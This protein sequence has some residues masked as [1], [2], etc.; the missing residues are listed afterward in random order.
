M[1]K[2]EWN[3]VRDMRFFLSLIFFCLLMLSS[4]SHS[5]SLQQTNSPKALGVDTRLNEAKER[6]KLE[7]SY[8]SCPSGHYGGPRPGR[9]RYTKDPWIWVV[10]PEFA[11]KYCMPEA[12]I[13]PDLK[14]AEAV[15]VKIREEQDEEICGW[16][17]RVEVC[18]KARSLRFEIYIKGEVKLP[19]END[20]PYYMPAIL[21]SRFLISNS[22][23]DLEKIRKKNQQ[24][25]KPGVKPIF[26]SSQ[27][28]LYLLSE[29]KTTIQLSAIYSESFF[30]DIF[31]GIDFMSFDSIT[32]VVKKSKISYQTNLSLVIAFRP[33][34]DKIPFAQQRKLGDFEHVI[35]LPNQFARKV[36]E[37]DAHAGDD[38]QEL[39]KRALGL[40]KD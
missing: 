33:V 8:R 25:P 35:Y 2:Y 14:G 37:L 4:N 39:A 16:G 26:K 23:H 32:G 36:A 22:L 7:Q 21:P 38:I 6:Q 9:V 15:A 20:L 31:D 1:R 3:R 5:Q 10:T 19:K 28:G 17:D 30:R 13:D 12:F 27:V 29:D 24:N 40:K 34:N 11:A 18:N